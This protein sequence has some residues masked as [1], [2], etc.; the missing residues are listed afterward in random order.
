VPIVELTSENWDSVVG[1][2]LLVM[3]D[4]W[5]PWCGPCQSFRPVFDQ[6]SEQH[7]DIVFG[8]VN[9]DEQTDLAARFGVQAI[10]TLKLITDQTVRGSRTGG[11]PAPELDLLIRKFREVAAS[12]L[13]HRRP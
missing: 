13:V 8:T 7:R 11:M 5:A 1:N 10:P 4:F 3:V 12:S 6:M 2:N 9:I